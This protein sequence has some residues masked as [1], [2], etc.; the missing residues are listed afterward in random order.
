MTYYIHWKSTKTKRMTK[1]MKKHTQGF[2]LIELIVTLA[3]MM[4]L[5]AAAAPSFRSIKNNTSVTQK[6]HLFENDLLIARKTAYIK[7]RK[8]KLCPVADIS[9]NSEISC[10]DSW[11]SFTPV[12]AKPSQGWVVFQ[13]SNNNN[14]I[15][16]S[17]QIFKT[18]PFSPA[19]SSLSWTG[20]KAYIEISPRST[21]GNT[22]TMRIYKQNSKLNLPAWNSKKPPALSG[23]HFEKRVAISPLGQVAYIKD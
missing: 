17:E 8:I 5:V 22:G 19:N 23:A 12:L 16:S 15:D 18:T 6:A 21:T 13:D 4:I 11:K 2:T 10:M 9:K 3:V 7:G 14:K 1:I 20:T